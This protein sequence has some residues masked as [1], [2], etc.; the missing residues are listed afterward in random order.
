MTCKQESCGALN[1]SANRMRQQEHRPT[2]PWPVL[3]AQWALPSSDV[4]NKGTR[5]YIVPMPNSQYVRSILHICSWGQNIAMQKYHDSYACCRFKKGFHFS[6]IGSCMFLWTNR[7]NVLSRR[8]ENCISNTRI[9]HLPLFS[10]L[11]LGQTTA[12][13]FQNISGHLRWL[14]ELL[15]TVS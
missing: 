12:A 4:Q 3:F 15:Y 10:F 1:M 14:Q 6:S 9:C 13:M 7:R 2:C 5:L 8:C 11:R